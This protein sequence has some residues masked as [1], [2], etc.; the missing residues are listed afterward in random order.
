MDFIVVTEAVSHEFK[1][2]PINFVAPL[3]VASIVTTLATFHP[4][5]SAFIRNAKKNVSRREV[6]EG[7]I[8]LL[9]AVPTNISAW[10][11]PFATC[12]P[13]V[14]SRCLEKA[15]LKSATPLTSQ[16]P[17]SPHVIVAA[18]VSWT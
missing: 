1:P 13:P 12:E 9:M 5:R 4:L 7:V 10:G 3:N 17:M 11:L 14:A 16:L 18:A 6:A 2:V 15:W 8:H